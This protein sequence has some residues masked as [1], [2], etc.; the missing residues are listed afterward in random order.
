[1]GKR[2]AKDS[3]STPFVPS[4]RSGGH[5][6]EMDDKEIMAVAIGKRLPPSTHGFGEGEAIP[7]PYELRGLPA[8]ADIKV[9][10]TAGWRWHFSA[11]LSGHAKKSLPEEGINCPYPGQTFASQDEVL[12]A[13]RAYLR[14]HAG[15]IV[16]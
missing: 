2:T 14:A 3:A 7:Q 1:M 9:Y 8:W 4:R 11:R 15:L 6:V 12:E 10:N 13:V 5:R 16:A